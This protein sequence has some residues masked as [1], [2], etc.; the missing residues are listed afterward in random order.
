MLGLGADFDVGGLVY[1]LLH[2]VLDELVEG[3]ELLADQ[4]LL[5]EVGADHRPR[6]FLSDLL[7]HVLLLLALHHVL[8][9]HLH[10]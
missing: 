10:P 7:L 4:S 9:A 2:C 5:L 6:V 8:V 1:N 3:I